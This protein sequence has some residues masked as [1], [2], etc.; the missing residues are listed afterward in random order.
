MKSTVNRILTNEWF[1]AA[2][3]T[4]ATFSVY[5]T[6][7]CRTVSFIDAG[8]LAAVV[9]VLGIAHPTGYPLF[10]LVAHCALWLPLGGEEILRLNI[11]AS[12]LVAVSVG[13]FLKILLTLARMSLPVSAKVRVRSAGPGPG[14]LISAFVAA[15][16]FG[17]STTVWAQSVVIEVYGL[18]LF[19][20]S[21]TILLFLRGIEETVAGSQEIPRQLVAAAFVLGL[22][23]S[24]H[25]TTLLIV[26]ALVTLYAATNGI[27]R[28]SLIR[29]A[30]LTP[31]FL[32]GLTPYF[33]LPVRAG[34]PP[35]VHWGFPAEFERLIWHVSGK[36]YRTWMFSSFESAEKQLSYFLNHFPSEYNLLLVGLMLVGLVTAFRASRKIF[37]F[38]VAAFLGCVLYSINYD[39][40]DIDSYFLLAYL[41]AGVF[42]FYGVTGLMELIPGRKGVGVFVGVFVI[43]LALPVSQYARNRSEVNEADN[44]LVADY[45]HNVFANTAQNGVILTFQW[46]YLV[47]AAL[48]FQLVRHEREDIVIID[49]ELLRRSW[50]F[51]FLR[52]RY[53]WLIERS[54]REVEAFLAELFKFEHDLAY[55]PG[56][57]E[58]RYVAMINSFIE[59]SMKYRPV[60]V[61]PEIEPEMG[62]SC[63]RTP[64]G[65]MFR[66]SQP[67]DTISV[68]P[69]V[70][71]YRPSSFQS[72][73][74]TG[75]R[76]LYSRMLT[77][78]GAGFLSRNQPR[79]AS[80]C[81]EKALSIDPTFGPARGL[82]EQISRGNRLGRE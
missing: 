11:F 38:L 56:A 13:V 5:L 44:Y 31:A 75:I 81:I 21:T 22:S 35:P 40:H 7:M 33:Y 66:L 24:N 80:Y 52:D 17:L 61:G 15:L 47:S 48:Y 19:L 63:S 29:A 54:K 76:G 2:I 71:D 78:T 8:E 68:K 70:V 67:V 26:P 72:R 69:I 9:S 16:S 34:T 28:D 51:I 43:L 73:L 4:L 18:H 65:M 59:Q 60:Y 20:L 42:L 45:V 79:E 57:I 46:D 3:V 23:F 53:P 30:K 12:L 55:S 82:R 10:S 58:S 1:L 6:T 39:I 50:Y 49:K 32:L 37:W 25:L 64:A 27:R 14:L 41:I 36:Q 74:T 62:S 77:A